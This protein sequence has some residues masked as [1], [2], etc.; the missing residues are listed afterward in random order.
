MK[1]RLWGDILKPKEQQKRVFKIGK[2][3]ACLKHIKVGGENHSEQAKRV[4]GRDGRAGRTPQSA[5]SSGLGGMGNSF[6]GHEDVQ[7]GS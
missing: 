1:K 3:L 7:T 2:I 4:T 6:W 5:K